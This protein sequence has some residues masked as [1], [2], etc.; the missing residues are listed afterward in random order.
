MHC[1]GRVSIYSPS[2]QQVTRGT[3][4]V[5]Y[6]IAA[7]QMNLPHLILVT[8]ILDMH[9]YKITKQYTINN[10]TDTGEALYAA[11]RCVVLWRLRRA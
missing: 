1:F 2:L 4:T 5:S 10:D 3:I 6:Y 11:R 9:Q 7:R 8:I